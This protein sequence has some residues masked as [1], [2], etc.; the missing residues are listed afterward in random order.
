M[1][2]QEAGDRAR[3][4]QNGLLDRSHFPPEW[5]AE[6]AAHEWHNPLFS[7]GMEYGYLLAM[8]DIMNKT[9]STE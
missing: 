7:Y 2:E 9:D 5:K 4:V 3:R 8:A 1:T 6:I